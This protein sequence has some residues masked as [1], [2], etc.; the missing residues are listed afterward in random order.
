MRVEGLRK[1]PLPVPHLTSTGAGPGAPVASTPILH[2]SP[3]PPEAVSQLPLFGYTVYVVLRVSDLTVPR[4]SLLGLNR[5]H[6]I[7]MDPSSQV[8]R[9]PPQCA[10][11]PTRPLPRGVKLCPCRPQTLCCSIAL[12][13]LHRLRLLSPLEEDGPP[14]LELNYGSTDSP[15]TIWFELPQVSGRAS[16]HPGKVASASPGLACLEPGPRPRPTARGSRGLAGE[17]CP[18]TPVPTGPG[19]EAHHLLPAGQRRPCLLAPASPNGTV[20]VGRGGRASPWT[21]SH[22]TVSLGCWQVT[23][24]WTSGTCPAQPGWPTWRPQGCQ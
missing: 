16:D 21:K 14:G 24:A 11:A 23:L 12:R 9:R 20:Q 19:A 3:P 5:Q 22:P 15:Q 6:L 18:H 10:R 17:R 2:P 4:P 8:G 7:L 1:P 13:D